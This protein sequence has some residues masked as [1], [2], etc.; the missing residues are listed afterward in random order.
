MK[1]INTV[2]IIALTL[3]A[4]TAISGCTSMSAGKGV[5]QDKHGRGQGTVK[6]TIKEEFADDYASVKAFLSSGEV[7][8]GKFIIAKTKSSTLKKRYNPKTKKFEYGA[9]DTT[10]F[11]SS[12]SGLLF[13]P[14]GKTMKCKMTLSD[15]SDG[16]EGG[17]IGQCNLSTGQVIPLQFE[18]MD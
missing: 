5:L 1:T 8:K 3:L 18:E 16:F 14:K 12:A 4:T 15:P 17:G 9:D 2:N 6:F 7:Y 10:N 13:G 11:S